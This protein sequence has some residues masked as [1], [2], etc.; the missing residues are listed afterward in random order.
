[1]AGLVIGSRISREEMDNLTAVA[2]R[3]ERSKV[4]IIRRALREYYEKHGH[5]RAAPTGTED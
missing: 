1:M 3:E 4:T 2:L 5:D